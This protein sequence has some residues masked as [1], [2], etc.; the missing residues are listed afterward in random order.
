M[1]TL[2]FCY[3]SA[4]KAEQ[5][6]DRM[7]QLLE[8]YGIGLYPVQIAY[9]KNG[10]VVT[11]YDKIFLNQKGAQAALLEHDKGSR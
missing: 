4:E 9:I 7:E 11:P 6:R 10:D 3:D 2:I 1:G 5:A 8:Q